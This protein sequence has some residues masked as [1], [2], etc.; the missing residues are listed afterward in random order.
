MSEA[1]SALI[2]LVVVMVLF[3]TE[4]LPLAV[5]ALMG[6]IA[7]AVFGII[8]F[9]QAFAGFGSDTLMMVAGM[10]IIGQAVYESGWSTAWAA[11]CAG[12]SRWGSARPL[13]SCPWWQACC[14]RS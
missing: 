10:L 4:A 1:G 14:R 13:R 2:I 12:S 5:T 6:A 3:V 7:M 9:D 11:F 8:G